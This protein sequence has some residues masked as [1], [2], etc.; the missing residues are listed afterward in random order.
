MLGRHPRIL[1]L[2]LGALVAAVFGASQSAA[3]GPGPSEPGSR[4]VSVGG[5]AE[6]EPSPAGLTLT[7]PA[8]ADG[9]PIPLPFSCDGAGV[10]PPLT[11]IDAPEGTAAY[12]LVME[13]Q[14]AYDFPHWT[15]LSLPGD[16]TALDRGASGALGDGPIEG[17]NGVGTSGYLAPCPPSGEH[18]YT[19]TLYALSRP[20]GSQVKPDQLTADDVRRL[21]G[22]VALGQAQLSGTYRRVVP[23]TP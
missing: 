9:D 21:V 20:V 13:D 7:S 23:A 17:L 8:F 2:A 10:S 15:V 12:A 6:P 5:S 4:L 16:W 3:G 14:S 11:W 18:A 22:D 1:I 19:V